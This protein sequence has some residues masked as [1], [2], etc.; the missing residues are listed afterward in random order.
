MSPVLSISSLPLS[1]WWGFS[2]RQ[3]SSSAP[4]HQHKITPDVTTTHPALGGKSREAPS[5]K[6]CSQPSGVGV[7]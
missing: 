5:G 7:G 4:E 6:T 3:S 1:C 2:L